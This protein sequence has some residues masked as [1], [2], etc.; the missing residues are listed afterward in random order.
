MFLVN[1]PRVRAQEEEE[2]GGGSGGGGGAGCRPRKHCRVIK[3]HKQ[4]VAALKTR[5]AK[6]RSVEGGGGG[7]VCGSSH[8]GF[9][10][11]CGSRVHGRK[12]EEVAGHECWRG[13]KRELR[14]GTCTR[15]GSVLG[16]R[17]V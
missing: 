13:A 15:N 14:V 2:D 1:L 7:Q 11:C 4:N 5:H 16:N 3:I 9:G 8:G 12:N 17:E 6:T 10:S